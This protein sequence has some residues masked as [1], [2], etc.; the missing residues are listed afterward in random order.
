MDCL[1][2]I[3][4][5]NLSMSNLNAV[6]DRILGGWGEVVFIPTVASIDESIQTSISNPILFVVNGQFP[7]LRRGFYQEEFILDP[8]RRFTGG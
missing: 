6:H 2:Q 7:I 5:F 4:L 1:T 8:E 3:C